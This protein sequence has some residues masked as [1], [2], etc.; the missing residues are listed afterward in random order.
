MGWIWYNPDMAQKDRVPSTSTTLLR[1]IGSCAEHARWSEF[2]AR[3]RP[4]MEAFLRDRYPYLDSDDVIQ[5]TL[6][7]LARALPS[8]RY[9]PK[10]TGFFRNYLTGVLRHKAVDFCRKNGRE[11]RLRAELAA[12]PPSAVPDEDTEWR[13]SVMEIAMRQLLADETIHSRTKQ[14]F[15]RVAVDG[16]S[17]EEVAKA[18]GVSRNN[19]DQIK[20][21][22][23]RKL[24]ELVRGLESVDAR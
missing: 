11:D 5:E 22:M 16:T 21:R 7:A 10:S 24:R 4:L 6:V 23:I 8:Y 9:D 14:I 2:E 18:Y 15:Q 13:E 20:D 1:E 3:Y 19:V 12:L 17:P